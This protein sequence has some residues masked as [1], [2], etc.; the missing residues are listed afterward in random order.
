MTAIL[1]MV[2]LDTTGLTRTGIAEALREMAQSF[3]GPIR[4]YQS[5]LELELLQQTQDLRFQVAQLER[6]LTEA[7]KRTA[8]GV[9]R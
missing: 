2:T 4:E 8:A 7:R 5:A 3:D 6:E 9:T 1:P